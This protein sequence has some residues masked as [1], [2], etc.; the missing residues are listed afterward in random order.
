KRQRESASTNFSSKKQ[1]IV[2]EISCFCPSVDVPLQ[3]DG[4]INILETVKST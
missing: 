1:C 2:P 4:S 3:A